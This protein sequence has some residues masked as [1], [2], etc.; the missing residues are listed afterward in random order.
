MYRLTKPLLLIFWIFTYAYPSSA[1]TVLL[2]NEENGLGNVEVKAVTKDKYGCIW[3]ATK[4]GLYTYD[5][6]IF[7]LF[8]T[9]EKQNIHALL[10][11]SSRNYLW[12]GTEHGLKYIDCNNRADLETI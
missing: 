3:V 10:F 9:L 8:P 6:S 7:R 1:R 12:V 2:L 5:G 4:G 11:D